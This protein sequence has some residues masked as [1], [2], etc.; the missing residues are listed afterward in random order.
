[1]NRIL[2]TGCGGIGGVNFVRALRFAET[3]EPFPKFY[4]LGTDFNQYYIRFA[5]T[6][7]SLRTPRHSDPN[8]TQT[9][10][11]LVKKNGIEFLHPNPSSE[12]RVVRQSL[13]GELFHG[14]RTLMPALDAIAPKKDEMKAKLE[15]NHVPT[16]SGVVIENEDMI[17][18]SF[19]K[20]GKPL[21][22]RAKEGAGARLS[23]KVNNVEE[24]KLWLNLC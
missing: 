2:V 19:S 3:I 22:I 13:E 21:W 8:F 16:P 1:M 4:I 17:D 18:E 24:A 5:E 6:D 23:L 14:A 10:E 15:S 12:A 20:L 11:G 7:Q 9:I